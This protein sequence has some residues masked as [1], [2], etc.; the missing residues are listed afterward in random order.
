MTDSEP[1]LRKER[2]GKIAIVTLNRPA[3][4]NALSDELWQRLRH[5]FDTM[6]DN[7]RAVVITGA[8]GHFCA[9]LDL[10]EHVG[11]E[12]FA[13]V[14][15]SR[16]AHA[17]LD[18]IRLGP[19]PVIAAMQGAVIGGGLELAAAAH[20]R[21]ADDT[22]FYQMPEGRRGIF[23]GGG[24]SVNVARIIGAS[25]LLE[26]MLTGRIYNA[27]AG[28]RLGLSHYLAD[29][30]KALGRAIELAELVAGNAQI[31]NYLIIQALP[32]IA[33]MA[34]GDGLWTESIAQ[35]LSLTSEEA[36]EGM[37]AFLERRKIDFG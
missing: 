28:E 1:V 22:A 14:A 11:R 26:M 36:R 10:S 33:D 29:K 4:R 35:A 18:A 16:F 34:S 27:D 2:R 25:R 31:P 21:V 30:G 9:G 20:I 37:Q 15:T 32:R 17:T 19:R 12:A 3:K 5:T 8:G 13:S 7:V 23:I 24:G 6:E